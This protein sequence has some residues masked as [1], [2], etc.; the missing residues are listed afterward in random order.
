MRN[1]IR[2]VENAARRFKDGER[3]RAFR[4]KWLRNDSKFVSRYLKSTSEPKLNLGCGNNPA[5]GWLNADWYPDLP[6][7]IH[8]NAV[9]PF[10]LPTNSFDVV[11]SEHMIEHMGLQA[12]INML[13]ECCRVLKPGG[14]I[15]VATPSLRALLQIYEQP[16]E[17]LHPR[18]YDWHIKWWLQDAPIK[19]PATILNDFVRNWGHTYIYDEP[20]LTEA[21][22]IAGFQNIEAC[23]LQ[24]SR[25]PRLRGL[26]NE[27]RMPEGL[28]DLHTMTLEAVKWDAPYAS[29]R[30]PV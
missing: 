20:S 27:S 14:R 10:P 9:E 6:G 11:Y 13:G 2:R 12:G 5:M 28:L 8:V 18:Y 30:Q 23:G 25:D 21:L 29:E 24:D 16:S 4:Q 22:R 26:A 19:S 3:Y 7:I 1:P 15:R 17:G